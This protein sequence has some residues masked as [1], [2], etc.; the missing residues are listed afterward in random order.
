MQKFSTRTT[1][2]FHESTV[3]TGSSKELGDVSEI[4]IF[5]TNIHRAQ[6]I[7]TE[8]NN[9]NHRGREATSCSLSS[10]AVTPTSCRFCTVIDRKQTAK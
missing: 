4:P 10:M 7:S 9:K 1:K 5:Q 2:L 6:E 3:S 8:I